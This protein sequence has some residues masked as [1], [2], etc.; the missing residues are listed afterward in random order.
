MTSSRQLYD[1]ISDE[2]ID[3]VSGERSDV[4]RFKFWGYIRQEIPRIM[5]H[6]R[7]HNVKNASI[8]IAHNMLVLMTAM[9]DLPTAMLDLTTHVTG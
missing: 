5:F 4:I 7:Y 6:H 3:V 2:I 1:V 8:Y 9:L